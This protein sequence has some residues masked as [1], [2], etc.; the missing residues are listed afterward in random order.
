MVTDQLE[1]AN[2]R[3]SGVCVKFSL[4]PRPLYRAVRDRTYDLTEIAEAHRYVDSGH[5]RGNVVVRISGSEQ[6]ANRVHREAEGVVIMIQ[7]PSATRKT[8][9]LTASTDALPSPWQRLL[10]LSGIAF[11]VL[12]LAGFLIS[13]S[14]APDYTASDQVWSTWAGDSEIRSR[15][16]A[17]LTLLASLVFLP[18][19]GALRSMFEGADTRVRG[20]VQLARVAFAGALIGVTGIT[21]AV[22]IDRRCHC[23]RR[24]GRPRGEQSGGLRHGRALSLVGAMGF[25]ASLT[26]TGLL[27]LR[28]HVFA[29][30]IAIVALLGGASFFIAFFTL[31]AGPGHDGVFGY[32]FFPGFLA[33]TI[34]SIATGVANYRR[35]G[36]P[37]TRSLVATEADS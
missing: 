29:R 28:S 2:S 31:L 18:F 5:K 25:A 33:L 22:I 37:T 11:A 35:V 36:A 15:I 34:W 3:W 14:D 4:G 27:I 8:A 24:R 13:G 10:A 21:M 17:F 32:G 23:R 6:R 19:T 7:G 30:W 16:G 12:F 9:T 20:P 26:A 1:K